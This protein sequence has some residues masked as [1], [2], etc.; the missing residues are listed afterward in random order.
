MEEYSYVKKVWKK[1][2]KKLGWEI[3]FYVV[4]CLWKKLYSSLEAPYKCWLLFSFMPVTSTVTSKAYLLCAK[5]GNITKHLEPTYYFMEHTYGEKTEWSPE[6]LP[7]GESKYLFPQV[8]LVSHLPYHQVISIVC[9]C[10]SGCQAS[11]KPETLDLQMHTG[12]FI[13]L[14]YSSESHIANM[15]LWSPKRSI[16]P[17]SWSVW[18]IQLSWG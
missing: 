1:K 4:P 11:I 16:A 17:Y 14:L 9:V 6:E 5:R 13:N 2:R 15:T 18:S 7:I 10:D 8:T 12:H 3:C